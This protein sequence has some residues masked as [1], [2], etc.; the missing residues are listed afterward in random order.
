MIAVCR[1]G[2]GGGFRLQFGDQQILG[3]GRPVDAPAEID[4]RAVLFNPE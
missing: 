4:N 3:N 2:N 1:R